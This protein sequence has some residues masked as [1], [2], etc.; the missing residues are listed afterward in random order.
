MEID[1]SDHTVDELKQ[2]LDDVDDASV[3]REALE[4]EEDGRD[5]KT[6]RE[7]IQ[8]RLDEV[9]GES[10]DSDGDTGAD[11]DGEDDEKEEEEGGLSHPTEDKQY[12]S[13]LEDGVYRDMWVY[14]ETQAGEMLD[15][16]KEMLGK[17][18]DLMDDYADDYGDEERVVAVVVGD[19][20]E[21][22]AHESVEYGADVAVYVEDPRLERYVHRAYAMAVADAMR[23][24]ADWRDYD[25]PRYV[26][27]P[28][29]NNG[30]DL[31]A[32]V[33]AE[34]DSGLASDC[35]DLF[36]EEH[37]ETNPMK[38]GERGT[39]KTFERVLHMKRPDF[40]GF[41]YSTILCLDNPDRDFHPQGASVIPGT[42]PVPEPGER[43]GLVVEHDAEFDDE[44]FDVEVIEHDTLDEGVDL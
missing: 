18:R 6:A 35:S 44:W 20:V 31:S 23:S 27:F 8:R 34:L 2:A 26:L 36:I 16:S 41:E 39:T 3:L 22:I 42:F 24:D 9:E 21:E 10:A 15:V 40:S 17:A 38:T 25:E 43:D 32:Q 5:R 14:C 4:A 13:Q 37:E 33:Q 12:L 19:E 30:R 28:A 1:P 11:E 29:T 7:A